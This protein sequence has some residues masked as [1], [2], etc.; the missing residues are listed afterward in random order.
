MKPEQ[1]AQT[2]LDWYD[3]HGRHDLPWQQQRTPYTVW[4]SE[5]MLQQTQ[6]TT[7]IPY[8]L[9]FI[10]TFPTISDLA[11][12]PLDTV[13]HLWT[14]LGYYARARNL[15]KAAQIIHT[16]HGGDFPQ[17]IETVMALPGVGRS[18]AGAILAQSLEQRHPIL[19][20]NVKRVL[21][22]L[23]AIVGP[24]GQKKVENQLWE[25]AEHY[26]PHT[27]LA[28]YTQAI[29]DLGATLCSRRP[30]CRRCPFRHD[31]AALQEGDPTAYP[32]PKARKELP[33]RTTQMLLLE[34]PA[35]YILLQQRPPTGIWGGLWSLPECPAD[36]D[37]N[38]WC[39]D[40]LGLQIET[41]RRGD[42]LRH[43][44][45]HFHLD[46]QPVYATLSNG[47][48]NNHTEHLMEAGNTVWYNCAQPDARGL[49]TPVKRLLKGLT[50]PQT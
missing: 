2:L 27:R 1:F 49:P 18:T 5:I 22:R 15:H 38:Q 47:K 31:C 11:L 39:R 4:L 13:L 45:S 29:M 16:E 10:D 6:V 41:T 48:R 23:H 50:E 42:N 35:G 43:T 46:I 26:T 3:S 12:A 20:G 9:R 36:T 32:T 14:G 19:D 24:P 30:D 34:N 7:V 44:F 17:D 28:D 37:I 8:Y 25:L 21:T 33:V 40:Q